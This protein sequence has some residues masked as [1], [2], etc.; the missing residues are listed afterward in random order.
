MAGLDKELIGISQNFREKLEMESPHFSSELYA[1]HDPQVKDTLQTNEIMYF[2]KEKFPE[3]DIN[4]LVEVEPIDSVSGTTIILSSK[5]EDF[6]QIFQNLKE[7]L[8]EYNLMVHKG[9]ED[10]KLSLSYIN[11]DIYEIDGVM[12]TAAHV[13]GEPMKILGTVWDEAN[14]GTQIPNSGDAPNRCRIYRGLTSP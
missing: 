4:K 9:N 14:T 7:R 6:N 8:S 2:R 13:L 11:N 1:I 5:G 10:Y 12:S 3:L